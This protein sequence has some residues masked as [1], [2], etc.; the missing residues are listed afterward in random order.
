MILA[1]YNKRAVIFVTGY[2]V[3]AGY[4]SRMVIGMQFTYSLKATL[5]PILT[6]L[7]PY[8]YQVRNGQKGSK[9]LESGFPLLSLSL[10]PIEWHQAL[11]LR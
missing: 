9:P 4:K 3:H 1:S 6:V 8:P 11:A 2:T 7:S 10:T 5:R